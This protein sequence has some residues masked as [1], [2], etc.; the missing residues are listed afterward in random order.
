MSANRG[1]TGASTIGSPAPW[2]S[3]ISEA[4]VIAGSAGRDK[5][6]REPPA[7]ADARVVGAVLSADRGRT[8][9]STIG[10]PAP[11]V[12]GIS[13]GDVIA[14]SACRDKAARKPPASA[15]GKSATSIPFPR[16]AVSWI[17]G[18]AERAGGATTDA[19]GK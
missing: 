11:W 13:E 19:R 9:A 17:S 3:G 6:A 2:V 15:T 5:A 14:G 8:E 4:E 16:T 10:S 7:C 12:S 18:E 1:R